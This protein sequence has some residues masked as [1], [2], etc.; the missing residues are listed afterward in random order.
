MLEGLFYG[1]PGIGVLHEEYAKRGR[2]DG[3]APVKACGEIRIEA[4]V[5]RVW[6]V[7][8]DLPGWEAWAPDV[9]GVRLDSAVVV[10]ARFAWA[11]G[12]TRIKS[13]FAVVEP[14]RELT[15]TGTALWTKA[16]DRHLLESTG[17]GAMRLCLEE[18]LAGALVPLFFGSA[19]LKAQHQ[20]WLT[21][22]K[23]AVEER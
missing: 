9:R 20:R 18:S 22:F 3:A 16:V 10:D 7:L 14:G 1:G 12:G 13:R 4:S 15:W 5:E 8:V 17:D 23:T 2:I 6:E 19:K 11:V 21:A